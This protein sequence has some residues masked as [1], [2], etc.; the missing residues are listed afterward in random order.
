MA[1]DIPGRT[2]YE[3]YRAA[4][5]GKSLATGAALPIWVALDRRIRAAWETAASAVIERY[6]EENP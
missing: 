6:A 4:A 2:A 1:R 3:A 5:A